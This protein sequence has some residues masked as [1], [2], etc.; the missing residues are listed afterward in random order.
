MRL[1]RREFREARIAIDPSCGYGGRPLTMEESTINHVTPLAAV[2]ASENPH[3]L[4]AVSFTQPFHDLREKPPYFGMQLSP[5]RLL[6]RPSSTAIVTA[7]KSSRQENA[8]MSPP[9]GREGCLV[10]RG[11]PR[12]GCAHLI[13]DGHAGQVPSHPP[14]HQLPVRRGHDV[15]CRFAVCCCLQRFAN[16]RRRSQTVTR[17]LGTAGP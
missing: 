8:A 14:D 3:G 15:R 16:L 17:R 6:M 2:G 11:G 9:V 13:R 1:R 10:V 7:P 5:K 4:E 12:H